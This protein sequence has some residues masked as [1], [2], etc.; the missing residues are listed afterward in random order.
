MSGIFTA[1]GRLNTKEKRLGDLKKVA[2]NAPLAYRTNST[3]E[4]LCFEYIQTFLDQYKDL[5]PKRALP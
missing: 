1:D 4:E 3:K 5:Y 2:V